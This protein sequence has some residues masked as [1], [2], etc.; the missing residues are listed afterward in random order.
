MYIGLSEK[1]LEVAEFDFIRYINIC[2]FRLT[3]YVINAK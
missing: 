3:F 2:T 1:G